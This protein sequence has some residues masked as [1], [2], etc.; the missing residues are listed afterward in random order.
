MRKKYLWGWILL[1]ALV[2]SLSLQAQTPTS[3]VPAAAITPHADTAQATPTPVL[4]LPTTPAPTPT[5]QGDNAPTLDD[6]KAAQ[7]EIGDLDDKRADLSIQYDVTLLKNVEALM[8][9]TVRIAKR[10][11]DK[12]L[13]REILKAIDDLE[14]AQKDELNQDLLLLEKRNDLKKL[15][16]DRVLGYNR[17]LVEKFQTDG[18]TTR[19]QEL[20]DGMDFIKQMK[21]L[22]DQKLLLDQQLLQARVA[23]DFKTADDIRK[24]QVDLRN[25]LEE[26]D[27]Q[28]KTKLQL[29]EE[30]GH[31]G[32]GRHFNQ[33]E[34]ENL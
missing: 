21:S 19:V 33:D 4:T 24:K 23:C 6:L 3:T 17:K 10:S 30:E 18:N 14:A 1:L 8:R 28:T 15:N 2:P 32:P 9:E 27:K 25:Q 26:L 11:G 7:K 22:L 13:A 31:P 29:L 12:R 16:L 5:L 34:P 20:N